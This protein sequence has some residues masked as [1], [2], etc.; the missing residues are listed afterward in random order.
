MSERDTPRTE[1]GER[2]P[3]TAEEMKRLE[4]QGIAAARDLGVFLDRSPTPYHAAHEAA[5]R[6]KT[7]GFREVSERDAWSFAPG[8]RAYI[9]R[10][11]ATIIAFSIGSASPA[12]AGFR[13][14]GA[15]TD[16]PN[17][18]V[19]PTPDVT[20]RGYQQLAVEPYGGVLYTTWLDR[21]LSLAGRVLL[22]RDGG[23]I[24]ARLIDLG[25]PFARIPNL[26][27]HLNRSVNTEGL[28]LNA[29]KH[30]APVVGL[31][32][33]PVLRALLAREL[34]EPEGSILSYDLALYDTTKAAILGLREELIASARLDNLASCHAA[35]R[36]L[37]AAA[38]K[39]AQ[40]TRVI[41]L[42]DHEEC[43]S[44]SAVGAA[45]SVLRDTLERLVDAH[46]ERE[47]QAFARA[48]AGSFLVSADMAHAIHPNYA[49]MHE[50]Q[51]APQLNRGLV[52]KSN[53]NQ[54]YA[55]EGVTASRFEALCRRVGYAP[56][57]YVVRSD[58]P[59]GSTIG[60]ITAAKLGI[61]TV[62]VGAPMLSMH[63]C[64]EVAG[65]LDVHLAIET[66]TQLF[67]A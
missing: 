53:S 12:K 18:R 62:D 37:I 48:M 44:R 27:I 58:M 56:Q 43:G 65:T 4:E 14:I 46:V 40:F 8:D 30:L 57:R 52:I 9:I 32:K 22:E 17:L 63:S 5:E 51:H 47:P 23:A 38:G 59:C 26:A 41:A 67:L 60:P 33:E 13:I 50:P 35:T 1:L 49:D 10:G 7:E 39:E 29:Q 64:R 25:R 45:G 31:G 21:D 24:E 3:K 66:Y 2:F 36:A 42:Y 55:T 6:L 28:V 19:K 20:S 16:S 61:A 54:S 34:G 15:H 11:G